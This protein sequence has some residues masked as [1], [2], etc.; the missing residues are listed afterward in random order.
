MAYFGYGTFK[1]S[2]L[3]HI[4][5]E[6]KHENIDAFEA[7]Q[8]VTEVLAYMANNAYRRDDAL[9]VMFEQ[10]KQAAKEEL[11]SELNKVSEKLATP[12]LIVPTPPSP[13]PIKPSRRKRS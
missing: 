6:V 13:T 7:V 3:E 4:E 11:L 9:K 1:Q 12:E 8:E 2:L 10:A 5:W